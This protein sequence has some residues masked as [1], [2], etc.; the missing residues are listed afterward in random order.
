[1]VPNF[2]DFYVGITPGTNCTEHYIY[3]IDVDLFDSVCPNGLQLDT[4]TCRCTDPKTS[5]YNCDVY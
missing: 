1:M 2:E 3:S 4:G 5:G